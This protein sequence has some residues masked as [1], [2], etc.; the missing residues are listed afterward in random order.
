[1]LSLGAATA[2]RRRLHGLTQPNRPLRSCG[3]EVDSHYLAS[4]PCR[5]DLEGSNQPDPNAMLPSITVAKPNT[6]NR[7]VYRHGRLIAKGWGG[8]AP[9]PPNQA[10]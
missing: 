1:M 6:V 9:H 3:R 4:V 8:W 2:V 5:S 10:S 7:A